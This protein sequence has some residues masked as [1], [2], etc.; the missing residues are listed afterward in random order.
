MVQQQGLPLTA[1]MTPLRIGLGLIFPE[2]VVQLRQELRGLVQ[3]RGAKFTKFETGYAPFSPILP[4]AYFY[5]CS[6]CDFFKKES[7]VVAACEVV[8]GQIAPYAWCFLWGPTKED[9][10]FSWMAR[11]VA[12]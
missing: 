4:G 1:L 5:D 11:A 12:L 8:E 10:P 9:A 3:E 7:A 2:T 6:T